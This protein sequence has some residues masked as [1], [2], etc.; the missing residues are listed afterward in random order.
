MKT[1]RCTVIAALT[2]LLPAALAAG[3]ETAETAGSRWIEECGSGQCLSGKLERETAYL[4]AAFDEET[5]RNLRNF[6]PD[7]MVDLL[8]MKLEMRF[9]DLEQPRFTA[10]ETL[11][12]RPIAKPTTAVT[13]DAIGLDV[14]NVRTQDGPVEFFLD[15]ETITL[16]FDPPLAVDRHHEI[17]F[18]YACDRPYAGMYF[19]PSAPDMPN[20]TAEVHTQ[21]QTI[22]NRHWFIAH[23]APNERMTTEL[24]VDVPAAYSVSSNGRLESQHTNGDRAVWHWMQDKPHV[25]YLVSLVIGQFD[26]VEIP[27]ER[28]PMKVWVPKGLGHLVPGTYGCTAEMIDL[29]ERRF[30]VPYPWDRYDQL[31]VK[32]FGAGGM[33]NTSATTMYPTAILD[34]TALADRNLDGLIAHELAHQWSGDL[35][36]CKDWAHIWL[37][38]GF[39]TYGDALW[40][41]Y[42]DG[43]DGYLEDIRGNFRRVAWRDKTTADLPMVSSTYDHPGET[44]RRPGNPYPKGASILH[45]LRMMLGEDVF[46]DGMHRYMKRNALGVVETHDFRYAMEEVSGRGLEWFFDQWCYRPGVPRLD[47]EVQYDG[48]DRALVVKIEQ[49]QEIDERTPAFRFTLPV[50]VRTARGAKELAIEVTEKATSFR[51]V[52]DGVPE[53]VAVDPRLHVL[54][55]V[56]V[57]KPQRMWERQVDDGPTIVARHRAIEQLGESDTPDNRAKLVAIIGD[58]S[59]SRHLRNAAVSA[60]TGFGSDEARAEV[61]AVLD[62]G[63]EDARVRVNL[64]RALSSYDLEEVGDRLAD[65]AGNDPSYMT[66]AAA[67]NGL[68]K[69]EAKD[70][71]DLLI[72]LVDFESQHDDVRRAALSALAD[73]DDPRGLDLAIRY[74]A[75]GH[76]DRSRPTAIRAIADLA[77]HDRDRAVDV[78][79]GLLD[80]PMSRPARAAGGA[81]AD[82]GDERA[83]APLERMKETHPDPGRREAAGG[84]LET[85]EK[86]MKGEDAGDEAPRGRRGRG[87]PD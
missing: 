80:D 26:I 71:A 42:R 21:G 44:F 48:R 25:S 55:V 56:N 32:N 10:V 11:R 86:A 51:T 43:E 16:R 67:I 50:Y 45:M 69:L 85:L 38:E 60:L 12:V 23:D 1:S 34:E 15:D 29:F 61:L 79:L 9:E 35:I 2:A 77:E 58:A 84:W 7:R 20:Y 36:T 3:G 66:R 76:M 28:V 78:L 72:D 39:A 65:F 24:I 27:H 57:T 81:I 31:V 87:G 30:G 17:V 8:H 74:A 49:T 75:Y 22:T 37:N 68:A 33:E 13:L 59:I 14:S 47:V 5:G 41:E 62:G 54:S 83:K 19:A 4:G 70:H 53:I 64:V 52:L 6:P 82:L 40:T 46:W 18:D 73:L 63:I